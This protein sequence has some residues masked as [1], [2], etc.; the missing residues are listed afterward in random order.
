MGRM[1]SLVCSKLFAIGKYLDESLKEGIQK[2]D[3][4]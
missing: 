3:C 2:N 4:L 1:A